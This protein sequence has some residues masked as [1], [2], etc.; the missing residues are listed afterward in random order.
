MSDAGGS[1]PV[2]VR[3]RRLR[4][5]AV[6]PRYMTAG[7]AGMDLSSAAD[8]PVSLAPGERAAI[9]TGLA[10]EIPRGYE[11]QVRPRSGL[12]RRAGVTLINAPGT[13][14][15]DYRGEVT[16]LLVNLGSEPHIIA[17]GDRIAQLVIAPVVEAAL[18]EAEELSDTTRG[19]G[20]F[21][22]TG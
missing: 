11:G 4:V 21:G 10:F 7:A 8:A 22:H 5:G 20:G 15:S 19:S 13:V 18:S 9:P 1:G 12:A 17:P 16:V 3:F 2:P 14:D 6:P